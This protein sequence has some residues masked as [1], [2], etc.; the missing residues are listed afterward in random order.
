MSTFVNMG[1]AWRTL[2]FLFTLLLCSSLQAR[3]TYTHVRIPIPND[4][5][6]QKLGS[7]GFA[8]EEG[9]EFHN[10][11]IEMI[12]NSFELKRLNENG[13]SPIVV[14]ANMESFFR[15]RL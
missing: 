4:A 3:E 1:K 2:V 13:F 8:L 14:R 15:N 12:V 11:E 9:V 10:R 5:A 6:W 7:L